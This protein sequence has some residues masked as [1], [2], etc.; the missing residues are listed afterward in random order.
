MN[1]Y[2]GLGISAVSGLY[3]SLWG[4]FKDAPYEG[5][6]RGTFPEARIFT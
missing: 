6:K 2:L 1:F 3:T 4:A 5:F